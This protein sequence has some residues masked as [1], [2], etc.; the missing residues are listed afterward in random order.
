MKTTT[1]YL[2]LVGVLILGAC[3]KPP[4]TD[5]KA[6]Y[7][8]NSSKVLGKYA[9]NVSRGF[10]KASSSSAKR[11]AFYDTYGYPTYDTNQWYSQNQ[12][13]GSPVIKHALGDEAQECVALTQGIPENCANLPFM[14]ASLA[15]CL[16]RIISYRNPLYT[17]AYRHMDQQGQQ[18]W[19]YLLDWRR[20]RT[21][22]Q[23]GMND[24]NQLSGYATSGYVDNDI[25][26]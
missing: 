26:Y 2:A 6:Q 16:D 14:V 13:Y 3:A 12:S 24:F 25:F 21:L 9:A 22:N 19:A 5:Q 20:P 18:Y 7:Q 11:G 10:K 23:F 4:M 17:Y 15:R 1:K 8:I